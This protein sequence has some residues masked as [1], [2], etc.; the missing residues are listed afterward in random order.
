MFEDR[1]PVYYIKPKD[2]KMHVVTGK[3]ENKET[4]EHDYVVARVTDI[5]EGEFVYNNE[6]IKSWRITLQG[7]Q[8]AILTLGYSSGF[9]RSMLN[10]LANADLNRPVKL[11][12]YVNKANFNSPSVIQDGKIVKWKFQEMPKTEK[13]KVGS[14]EAINDEKAVEWTKEIVKEIQIQLNKPVE[15]QDVRVEEAFAD[16]IVPD[17]F[18]WDNPPELK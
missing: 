6:K 4:T 15:A 18:P 1:G 12:C 13:V 17:D 9:T 7:D 5:Q 16:E 8:R 11:G 10:S 14:K 3:G 2:G